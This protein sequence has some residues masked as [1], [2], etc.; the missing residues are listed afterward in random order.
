MRG[1]PRY[2]VNLIELTHVVDLLDRF[3]NRRIVDKALT[4]AGLDRAMLN[5][6]KGFIPYATEAVLVEAV[7]REIGERHLGA[8]VGRY[9][10]YMTYGAYSIYVLSA[11]DLATAL[12]RGRRAML[13][14]HPGSEIVLRRTATHIVVG[15]NSAGFAVVG[16]RHLDEAT[17][18]VISQVAHHFLGTDWRPDW[19]EL[20]DV[21]KGDIRELERLTGTEVRTDCKIPSVA[22]RLNELLATNPGA[23]DS[24]KTLSLGELGALMEVSPMQTT[25]EAVEQMLDISLAGGVPNEKTVSRFLAISP[26]TLQRALKAEGTSFRTVRSSFLAKRAKTL[27]THSETSV[28]DIARLLGYSDSRAFRRAFN[29]AAGMSPSEFRRTARPL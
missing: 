5:G 10:D 18:F 13:F 3:A 17:P 6:S 8:K 4:V 7:A 22:I 29:Q 23:P 26:R 16:H 1:M 27:L 25:I 14:I 28:D 11:P 19:V 2:M 20:P 15:R 9:F 12:D 21:K 24:A